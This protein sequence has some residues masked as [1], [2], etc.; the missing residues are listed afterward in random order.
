MK[1]TL[2]LLIL[3]FSAPLLAPFNPQPHAITE[4]YFPELDTL[5]EVTPALKKQNGYTNY[6]ELISFLE[7]LE[8]DFPDKVKLSYIGKSKKGK[9]IPMIEMNTRNKQPKV[10]VWMQGGLHGDEQG[11]TEALLYLLHDVLYRKENEAIR[12]GIHLAIVPMANIDGYLKQKRNNAENLDLNRDQTKLMAAESIPLKKAYTNFQPQVA[13]DFH[14]YRPFRRDYLKMGSFG[15]T[16]AYDVMLLY[17][18]NLN[19]PEQ[20]RRFTSSAFLEP[21]RRVLDSHQLT[22]FDYVTTTKHFGEVHFNRGASSARSS[23]T[24]YALTNAISTLVEVRGVGI[25]R[26]SFKRRVFTGYIIGQ[27]Y[28][29]QALLHAEKLSDVL[30]QENRSPTIVVQSKRNVYNDTMEFI[31]VESVEKIT[32]PV[33]FRDALQSTPKLERPRPQGY[34]ITATAPWIQEK[35]SAL[36]LQLVVLDSAQTFTVEQYTVTTAQR[37]PHKY[38]KMTLQDVTTTLDRVTITAAKGSLYLSSEQPNAAILTEVLEP[39]APNSF[40]SFGLIPTKVATPL[41]IYRVL[42]N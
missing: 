35:L 41:P 40:V 39:E 14:E 23:A 9:A 24:N 26:T 30:N 38:E 22:H 31:D 27:T 29:Q 8:R 13:I 18:G 2:P 11:S 1:K 15:V 42:K 3:L 16:G 12:S 34:L 33:T 32:L 7:G 5:P 21:T 6:N 10:K 20:Q 4:R 36:G 19:V 17:T 25:G 28:L 37:Q